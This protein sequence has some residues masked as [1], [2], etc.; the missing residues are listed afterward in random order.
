MNDMNKNWDGSLLDRHRSGVYPLKC[1]WCSKFHTLPYIV[2]QMI[3]TMARP[4][5]GLREGANGL[6]I[7]RHQLEACLNVVPAAVATCQ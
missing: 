6:A 4:K 7:D 5:C 2:I 1:G 3:G